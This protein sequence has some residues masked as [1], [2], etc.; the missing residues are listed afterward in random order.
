MIAW[1]SG[2]RMVV[3]GISRPLKGV[4]VITMPDAGLDSTRHVEIPLGAAV[5]RLPVPG[6]AD[7][8]LLTV[9]VLRMG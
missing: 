3:G 2:L 4:G 5:Q 6:A 7:G 9:S 1:A 8:V